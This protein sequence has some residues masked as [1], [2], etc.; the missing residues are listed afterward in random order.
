MLA[1]TSASL[2]GCKTAELTAVAA[3]DADDAPTAA[4]SPPLDLEATAPPPVEPFQRG[5]YYFKRGDYGLAETLFRETVE[6]T[7]NN[8]GAWIALA[9]SYDN[10]RRFGFADRAYARA[11]ALA[12]ETPQ[13]LNN[14]A[15]SYMLRGDLRTARTKLVR[16]LRLDP[17]NAIA[18]NNL[19]LVEQRIFE[20]A[21]P[22]YTLPCTGK[23]C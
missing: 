15:M 11:I 5:L 1:L 19:R 20:R 21:R 3:A 6:K 13:I 8:T 16:A 10:I 22:P 4:V 17:H 23:S 9:A 12:G 2:A 18:R 7:P 14:Q